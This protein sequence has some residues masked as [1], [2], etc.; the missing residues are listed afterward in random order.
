MNSKMGEMATARFSVEQAQQHLNDARS[1][2]EQRLASAQHDA[3]TP[4]C[5]NFVLFDARERYFRNV[6][7]SRWNGHVTELSGI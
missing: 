6:L 2:L 1:N 7:G 3:I 4:V 5:I